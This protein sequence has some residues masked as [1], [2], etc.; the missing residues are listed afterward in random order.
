[1][2]RALLAAA[3]LAA[4]GCPGGASRPA[5]PRASE[6][7]AAAGNR[8]NVLLI[9]I[10]TLRA[11]HLGA[12]G[13][14]RATSPK[15]DALARRGVLFEQAYTYWP[16]TRGSFVALL[17]GRLAAQ[18]GYGKTHPT[19][20]D[21]NPTLASVLQEAGY[22][23]AAVVD[24]ANV[25]G[26]LGYSKGFKRYRETWEEKSLATEVDKARAITQ[27]ATAFL[28]AADPARAFLLWLHYVNPH[29]PYEPPAPFDTAF[30]D[31][32]SKSGPVLQPVSGFHGGVAREWAKGVR[33]LGYYVAQYDGEIATADAEVGRVLDALERS[34]VRDRTL[35]LLASDHGESL[36]EHDYYFDH[37]ENLF[38]PSLRVPLILAGPGIKPGRSSELASTLDI[39]PTLL[40]AVK[41]S[42]PPDLAGTSLLG[43]LRGEPLARRRLPG[44]N[45]R[46]LLATW[47]RR[48]KL[49]AT[50]VGSEARYALYDRQ[51]DPGETRDAGPANASVLREE[52]RELEL[53]RERIDAQLVRTRRLLEGRPSGEPLSIEACDRLKAMGYVGVPGCS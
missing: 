10:D 18:S 33:P 20:V 24:N 26:S 28:A 7:S 35:V 2:R 25:A 43:A 21:F 12:Y 53:F 1:V 50:P 13:Y 52:R 23:T 47:D 16:K 4:L 30:L 44:Q 34:A 45:D 17:T 11:D 51:S 3:A 39:V 49:V 38:D 27:D 31:A 36:G 41:V 40:D 19:L 22:D 29:A 6:R 37:G 46:N 9:T 32:A 15:I 14:R 5:Q 42:Y 48:Y 8:Q